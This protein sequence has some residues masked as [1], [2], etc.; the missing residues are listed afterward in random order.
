[1]RNIT[2]TNDEP[3]QNV[4]SNLVKWSQ[5]GGKYTLRF[6]GDSS[7]EPILS[8]ATKKF[9]IDF[10]ILAAGIEKLPESQVG[11]MLV[12]MIGEKNEIE[13]AISFL[14]ENNVSVQEESKGEGEK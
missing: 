8:R 4:S 3:F 7:G 2:H 14:N 6:A 1:M 9:D 5:K 11:T 13:K 10:N 12:D